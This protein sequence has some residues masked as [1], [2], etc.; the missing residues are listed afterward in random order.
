M[1]FPLCFIGSILFNVI[2]FEPVLE[3]R[4]CFDAQLLTQLSTE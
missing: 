2:A 4:Y 1:H 3:E